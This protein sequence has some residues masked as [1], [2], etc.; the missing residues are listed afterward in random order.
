MRPPLAPL[1][2]LALL[3]PAGPALASTD[4]D[5][6]AVTTTATTET[7]GKHR[8]RARADRWTV[9]EDRVLTRR[10]PG[11]LA[12]DRDRHR[13]RAKRLSAPLHGTARL[14]RRGALV[15]T[16]ATDHVG[17]DVFRY[18]ATDTR[19]ASD[20][21]TV[22][23]RTLPV[24]DAPTF[25]AGADQAADTVDGAQAVPGWATAISAGPADEAGQVVGFDVEVLSGSGLFHTVPAVSS[26]GTLTYAPSLLAESGTA[27]V[28]V[29]PTDDGGTTRGGVDTGSP[30]SFEITVTAPT[31][32][33][34]TEVG[35]GAT[36]GTPVLLEVVT[37]GLSG[38]LGY[39]LDCDGDGEFEVVSA[40]P[41]LECL[42]P[43]DGSFDPVVRVVDALGTTY[44]DT[45][46][47]LVANV[48]PVVT[49]PVDGSATEQV[50]ALLPLG[51][52][53]DP[54]D[55]GPWDVLVDWGD[56]TTSSFT[57]GIGSLGDLAHTWDLDDPDLEYVVTVTVTEAGGIASG[58]ATVVVGLTG[59]NDAPVASACPITA[60]LL[61]P[62]A[63]E[64]VLL[65]C[66]SDPD[67]DELTLESV[68]GPGGLGVQEAGGTWT[69]LPTVLGLS[70]L[71]Y[72]VTDGTLDSD[73]APA[74]VT[75][76]LP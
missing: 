62:L 22:T 36:E 41:E 19:G 18:R 48:A 9:V 29:T 20:T 32:V 31:D 23:V 33:V 52:F 75:V 69:I 26:D 63:L 34:L 64:G 73:P 2:T 16:P 68:T 55:D 65:G 10:A 30:Q 11:V 57:D 3:L 53:T 21:A 46:E 59:V 56:G 24:N 40:A 58:T 15:Y 8:P 43:D 74:P 70:D 76:T 45:T 51:S 1:L 60:V 50:S 25:T 44:D 67:G 39:H 14:S 71:S 42:Y 7:A 66:A 28:Q 38:A 35:G 49:G 6:A 13:L 17:R 61:Q 72:V 5:A 4:L 12:N 27:V 54:G 37:E 47:V